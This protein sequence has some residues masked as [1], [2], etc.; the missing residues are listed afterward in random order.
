M[1]KFRV[2]MLAGLLGLVASGCK[3]LMFKNT[4]G[5][6]EPRPTQIIT[7]PSSAIMHVDGAYIGKSPIL[8]TI[9]QTT[10]GM[11][12]GVLTVQAFPEDPFLSPQVIVFSPSNRVDRVPDRFMI[13]LTLAQ[14]NHPS[15]AEARKAEKSFIT[16]RVP[17]RQPPPTAKG[18]PVLSPKAQKQ[19]AESNQAR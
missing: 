7:Y 15:L 3:S 17:W 11:I 19:R 9:P 8:V 16:S 5:D 14:T 13:D 6:G 18:Q 2:A 12:N 10:N 1:T 4:G